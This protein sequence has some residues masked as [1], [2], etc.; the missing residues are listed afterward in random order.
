MKW[1][2]QSSFSSVDTH[3]GTHLSGMVP[4]NQEK[5]NK[6]IYLSL[7]PIYAGKW[8]AFIHI[9]HTHYFGVCLSGL[10]THEFHIFRYS[11]FIIDNPFI[12]DRQSHHQLTN[13][14]IR[15]NFLLFLFH[16]ICTYFSYSHSLNLA[17]LYTFTENFVCIF[18]FVRQWRSS[19]KQ[20]MWRLESSVIT[21]VVCSAIHVHT[22]RREDSCDTTAT[23]SD[24]IC[25]THSLWLRCMYKCFELVRLWRLFICFVCHFTSV[26]VRESSCEHHCYAHYR[27]IDTNETC[28]FL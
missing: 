26:C 3:I 23:M 11:H 17:V 4:K 24:D 22:D 16:K 10:M 25:A 15:K 13:L 6:K 14:P 5:K 18:I 12:C 27:A 8:F 28:S 7:W 21:L 19:K 2:F 1:I 9:K 20:N